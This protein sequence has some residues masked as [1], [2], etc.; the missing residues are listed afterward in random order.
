MLTDECNV[1]TGSNMFL[2]LLL[3]SNP[4]RWWNMTLE[5]PSHVR[6]TPRQC[7]SEL[8]SSRISGSGQVASL[9]KCSLIGSSPCQFTRKR[10]FT[11]LCYSV[12]TSNIGTE[13]AMECFMSRENLFQVCAVTCLS[14]SE[15]F[16]LRQQILVVRL[17]LLMHWTSLPNAF[18]SFEA[19]N[20][21]CIANL[22]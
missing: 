5:M 7:A 17:E 14:S 11:A 9:K 3:P 2:L 21:R 8:L 13:M 10:P 16:Y 18:Y 6:P 1:L 12:R 20:N 22:L 19:R 4:S 15:L